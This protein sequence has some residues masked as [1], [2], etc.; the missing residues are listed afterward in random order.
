MLVLEPIRKL[1]ESDESAVIPCQ[2]LDS[3]WGSAR[4]W[5]AEHRRAADRG[6]LRYPSDLTDALPL[7]DSFFW[8]NSRDQP[9]GRGLQ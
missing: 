1:L 3:L 4:M 6:G 5:T 7:D 2:E 8:A 9:L